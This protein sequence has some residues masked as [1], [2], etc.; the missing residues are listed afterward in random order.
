M[1]GV[2][3][4]VVTNRWRDKATLAVQAVLEVDESQLT[5]VEVAQLQHLV[6]DYDDV[7]TLDDFEHRAT[8]VTTYHPKGTA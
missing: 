7:F 6:E 3:T 8:S 4:R 2:I 1:N 5:N